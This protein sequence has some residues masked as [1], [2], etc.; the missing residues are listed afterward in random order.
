MSYLDQVINASG[1]HSA[2]LENL[3]EKEIRASLE[4]A[5]M[6][7]P[8]EQD[9]A[10]ALLEIV[11]KHGKF[12]D[13]NTGVWA[14]Y[15][16]A[17]EN[18]ENAEIGVKCGNCIFWQAPNGCSIIVAET[19]EGGLCRFAVL[20]DGT[21]TATAGSKPAPKKDQI[22]GSSKN[23]SGSASG[24]KSITF[25]KKV[26]ASLQEKADKHNEKYGD[27]AS[28]K[29]SLKTLK[30]VYRRGAGAFSTSHRPDQNRNSWAMARVN[31]FLHLLRTGKPKNSKY[32]TDNDLLPASHPRS[33][34]KDASALT[35][36]SYDSYIDSQLE[37][38]LL[39]KDQ[40]VS[41]EHAIHSLAEYSGMGYDIIPSIRAAWV[42]GLKAG[43]D[44]YERASL[45]ATQLH[46]SP[47]SDLLPKE[48][49]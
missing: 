32:T 18:T 14:G 45:L 46:S 40:Y 24:G 17:K 1:G 49:F 22:K 21:V 23:P 3:D 37:I 28:K 7:V 44:P 33:S 9:L 6:L 12:N 2:P 25:S 4:A 34:K 29:T 38:A 43:D 35:A 15:T 27:T 36:S 31:A 19:E 10:D 48:G 13:D 39:G 42:R 5:G 11:E 30:A 20:P 47:D 8:E 16:S 41:A 26:E